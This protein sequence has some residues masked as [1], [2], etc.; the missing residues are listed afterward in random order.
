GLAYVLDE[1]GDFR[2]HCNQEMVDLDPLLDE[3]VVKVQT[4][5]KKHIEKTESE[6]A[7]YV[8][9]NWDRLQSKFI[10]VFPKDFKRVI[11][12]RKAKAEK[13]K[14]AQPVGV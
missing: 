11:L 6:R 9:E 12:E 3:D 8:L 10:K 13:E 4:L 1:K 7:Q 5:L 14:L 2:I